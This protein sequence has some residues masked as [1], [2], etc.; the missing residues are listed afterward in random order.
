MLKPFNELGI[1]HPAGNIKIEPN[2]LISHTLLL[3]KQPHLSGQGCFKLINQT[4]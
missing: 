2:T 4:F 3:S 1:I